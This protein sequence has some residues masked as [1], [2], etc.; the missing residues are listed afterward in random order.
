MD[1]KNEQ[2]FSFIVS[3]AGFQ[4]NYPINEI[5]F[6]SRS[7]RTSRLNCFYVLSL[8]PSSFLT[9][10]DEIIP[11]TLLFYESLFFQ[12]DGLRLQCMTAR[13]KM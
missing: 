5:V 12:Y 13:I 9:L 3:S 8:S 4:P 11:F 1:F 7:L 2:P 6:P 10:L